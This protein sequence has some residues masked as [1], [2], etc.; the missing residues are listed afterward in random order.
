MTG[1]QFIYH[2]FQI[3][4]HCVLLGCHIDMTFV[5]NTEIVDSP[6]FDVVEFLGIFNAP[7]FHNI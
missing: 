6:T 2:L 4:L 5:V 3:N 1:G 7:L